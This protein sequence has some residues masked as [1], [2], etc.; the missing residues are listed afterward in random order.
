MRH[1]HYYK[2]PQHSDADQLWHPSLHCS[3]TSGSL[4]ADSIYT[5]CCLITGLGAAIAGPVGAF[6]TKQYAG[7]E[8]SH[9]LLLAPPVR[10]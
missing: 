3:W 4:L 7:E 8:I 6:S 5:G 2:L 9:A 10:W 1:T